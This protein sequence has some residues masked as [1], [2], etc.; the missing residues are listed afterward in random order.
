MSYGAYFMYYKC[1]KCGKRFKYC[2]DAE[3]QNEFG[4][5]DTCHA[6]GVLV[7]E[8]CKEPDNNM[9]YEDISD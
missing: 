7:G 4:Q 6:V 8:G 1:P 9:E 5:C 2:L 3:K